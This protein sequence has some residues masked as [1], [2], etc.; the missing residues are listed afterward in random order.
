MKEKDKI[1]DAEP[2]REAEYLAKNGCW[3]LQALG[4]CQVW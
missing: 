3:G 1:K 4:M 2:L